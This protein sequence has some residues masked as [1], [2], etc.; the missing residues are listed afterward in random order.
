[1]LTVSGLVD[2]CP[3][4]GI[5]TNVEATCDNIKNSYT[6]SVRVKKNLPGQRIDYILYHP[7]SRMQVDVKNYCLPL[8]DRVPNHCYSYSDHEAVTSTFVITE[9]KNSSLSLLMNSEEKKCV[10]ENCVGVLNKSLRRLRVNHRIHYL[11]FAT[12][13]LALLLLSFCHH[14]SVGYSIIFNVVRVILIVL[15]T[16]CIMMAVIWNKIERHGVLA[17]KLAIE[18]TLRNIS[19][20]L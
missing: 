17:G 7:S 5:S 13:L 6:T 3:T 15:I 14:S 9:T 2:A 19:D 8:P 4:N 11:L 1:M 12:V 20:D 10:L 18:I 16:Y